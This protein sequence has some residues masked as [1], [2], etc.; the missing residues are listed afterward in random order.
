MKEG[1]QQLISDYTN[2]IANTAKR[3]ENAVSHGHYDTAARLSTQK[4]AYIDFV[5]DEDS[6]EV[7]KIF[8]A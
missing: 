7:T 5:H 4:K 8:W 6:L 3:I 2:L 1:V